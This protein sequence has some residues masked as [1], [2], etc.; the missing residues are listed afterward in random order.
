M[1]EAMNANVSRKCLRWRLLTSASAL[2]L[3]VCSV[4]A[5]TA[6]ADGDSPRVWIELGGQWEQMSSSQSIFAPAFDLA[7]PRPSFETI[8]PM[9]VERLPPSSVGGEGTLSLM[10]SGTDWVFSA[11]V[12]Y[13]RAQNDRQLLEHSA[14]PTHYTSL[15]DR[16][17][18]SNGSMKSRE[19]HLVLDF[20]AGK[21]FGL[22]IFGKEGSSVASLGVRF[23]Q[24]DQRSDIALSE[25]PIPGTA[26]GGPGANFTAAAQISRSFHGIGPSL[27]WN[28]SAPF[29]GRPD[30]GELSL[31][32]GANAALLFGRQRANVQHQTDYPVQTSVTHARAHSVTVPNVGGF[33]GVSY[34][35]ENFKV[36]LG[37]RGDF[38]FGAMD[39]GIDTAHKEN[40]GFYGPFLNVAVGIGR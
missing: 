21:D 3:L 4:H 31:D 23:A 5:A 36:K 9:S 1:S 6:E 2:S 12:R 35:V 26:L 40:L 38:F 32:W 37:Y 33:A 39:G 16:Y 24:F 14:F 30:H 22:G 19:A 15:P 20:Q 25:N 27:S 34:R 28:G 8:S 10:P 18:F 17:V 7:T 13:G 29:L 11:S